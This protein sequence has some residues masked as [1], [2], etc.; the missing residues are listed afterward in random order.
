MFIWSHIPPSSRKKRARRRSLVGTSTS[1]LAKLGFSVQP[2]E[3]EAEELQITLRP[4]HSTSGSASVS[5]ITLPTTPTTPASVEL[6]HRPGVPVPVDLDL[7]RFST[8]VSLSFISASPVASPVMK[9]YRFFLDETSNGL[10]SHLKEL[11]SSKEHSTEAEPA[12]GIARSSKQVD[13]TVYLGPVSYLV[14]LSFPVLLL[15]SRVH[16]VK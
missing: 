4:I 5:G 15:E 13:L 8:S 10:L 9:C 14:L 11:V 1:T 6:S 2:A 16:R 3:E 7:D 12:T